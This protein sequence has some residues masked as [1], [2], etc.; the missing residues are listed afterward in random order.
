MGGNILSN[1]MSIAAGMQ[2]SLPAAPLGP[3]ALRNDAAALRLPRLLTTPETEESTRAS[4]CCVPCNH[5]ACKSSGILITSPIDP[6][7]LQWVHSVLVG[8]LN[9]HVYNVTDIK[10]RT[11]LSCTHPNA[12]LHTLLIPRQRLRPAGKVSACDP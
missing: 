8:I 12:W 10:Q 4:P 7:L 9:Q 11:P 3:P 2:P 5:A 1:L 6:S